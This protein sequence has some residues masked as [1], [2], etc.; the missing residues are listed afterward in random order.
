M[1]YFLAGD[2]TGAAGA[3]VVEGVVAAGALVVVDA[4]AG[5][6][7]V[8]AV[9]PFTA[10]FFAA[11]FATSLSFFAALST[12]FAASLGPRASSSSFD[13]RAS[14]RPLSA[15]RPWEQRASPRERSFAQR[16]PS[17]SRRMRP[18]PALQQA[19]SS[20]FHSSWVGAA[21]KRRRSA[22][23]CPRVKRSRQRDAP[24]MSTPR[25]D[26]LPGCDVRALNAAQTRAV[27]IQAGADR[28]RPA[29]LPALQPL[30][31]ARVGVSCCS[32]SRISGT[33][34]GRCS[35]SDR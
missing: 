11:S 7:G 3:A 29:H 16:R 25:G 26:P 19:C 20:K 17:K 10:S 32:H 28:N 12:G 15:P 27:D 13:P 14:R 6:A 33:V 23:G 30:A 5:A 24:S 9:V 22:T 35:A 21:R 8:V 1:R 31:F 2:V 4:A 34:I 18:R